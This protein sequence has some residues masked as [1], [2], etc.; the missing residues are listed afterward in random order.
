MESNMSSDDS[1]DDDEEEEVVV[2]G[3]NKS[4]LKEVKEAANRGGSGWTIAEKTSFVTIVGE[5]GAHIPPKNKVTETWK[6]VMSEV[7]IRMNKQYSR[8]RTLQDKYKDLVSESVGKD[9]DN[10]A[11]FTEEEADLWSKLE[12]QRKEIAKEVAN[13]K[14]AKDK[15]DSELRKLTR[16][17]K[18]ERDV[19]SKAMINGVVTR[20]GGQS[21]VFDGDEVKAKRED[22]TEFHITLDDIKKMDNKTGSGGRGGTVAQVVKELAER[23]MT[24]MLEEMKLK[25]QADQQRF[26]L[27][28]QQRKEEMRQRDH[29]H[30][31]SMR[32]ADTQRLMLLTQLARGGGIDP[33]VLAA[34]GGATTGGANDEEPP[35]KKA[36]NTK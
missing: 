14:E 33:A 25:A 11:Q 4:P 10:D 20:L 1:D 18:E 13:E 2:L 19:A 29:Q 24:V 35:H 12:D 32:A 28:M 6:E 16:E 7:K 3:T 31:A 26:E 5:K 8:W 15:K 34:F 23:R 22:G 17:G 9:P 27:E 21:W 30:E 36:R